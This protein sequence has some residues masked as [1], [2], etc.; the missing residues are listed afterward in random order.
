MPFCVDPDTL[1]PSAIIDKVLE[2]VQHERISPN[3][4]IAFGSSQGFAP[5]DMIAF[6]K[7]QDAVQLQVL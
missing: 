4:S 6:A 2:K 5:R 7:R 1:A 3:K